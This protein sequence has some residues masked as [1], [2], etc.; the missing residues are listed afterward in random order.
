MIK[1]NVLAMVFM[2]KTYIYKFLIFLL[3]SCFIFLACKSPHVDP[4]PPKKPDQAIQQS[5]FKA[6]KDGL[7]EE[8][9]EIARFNP[10]ELE[11]PFVFLDNPAMTPL[12][13]AVLNKQYDIT[14]LLLE[15]FDIR[16]LNPWHITDGKNV[17]DH[18]IDIK[19]SEH[20][21]IN[22]WLKNFIK[23]GDPKQVNYLL[24]DAH[25]FAALDKH[26][27]I[28]HI[29]IY[30]KDV[31]TGI[32][33][34]GNSCYA[35]SAMQLLMM[36][37]EGY[38]N[39]AEFKYMKYPSESGITD[40]EYWFLKKV[41][42][43]RKTWVS[44]RA[45]ADAL[46]KKIR[47][48]INT[49]IDHGIYPGFKK[50]KYEQ[51]DASEFLNAIIERTNDTKYP[52]FSFRKVISYGGDD[53][54]FDTET[55]EEFTNLQLEILP[56]TSLNNLFANYFKPKEI[57]DFP[58]AKERFWLSGKSDY[59]FVSLKRFAYQNDQTVKL[60]N[61]IDFGDGK[62]DL[63]NYVIEPKGVKYNFEIVGIS[64]HHGETVSSGHYTARVKYEDQ[65]FLA[66]DSQIKEIDW[67]EVKETAK[68]ESYIILLKRV[69]D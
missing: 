7:G 43:F 17:I 44:G 62:I 48:I 50:S 13:F 27:D 4:A 33:N 39:I 23:H 9:I 65:W 25:T 46:G 2:K 63:T 59:L 1:K 21:G 67:L 56:N 12:Q 51:E 55:N 29:K 49:G 47:E 58:G 8:V 20:S 28:K 10:V 35:N 14:Y 38:W 68:S 60:K 32:S 19:Q 52:S 34:T 11:E 66:N 45:T 40:K 26:F 37:D 22:N 31:P 16:K 41:F 15:N 6:I 24:S 57:S 42:S 36:M 69:K 5:L 30:K 64:M 54:S 18:L 3:Y 61:E 53:P